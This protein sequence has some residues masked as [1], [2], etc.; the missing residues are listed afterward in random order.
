[1]INWVC[2]SA[3]RRLQ[4]WGRMATALY[5]CGHSI[6]YYYIFCFFWAI[7][8]HFHEFLRRRIWQMARGIV[9]EYTLEL[10]YPKEA[11]LTVDRSHFFKCAFRNWEMRDAPSAQ[12]ILCTDYHRLIHNQAGPPMRCRA[13]WT[14]NTM[15]YKRCTFTFRASRV[16]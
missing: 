13:H 1:M 2:A 3:R 16:S 8:P 15:I 7:S 5:R 6:F 10:F 9:S 11:C 4:I 14:N 12:L